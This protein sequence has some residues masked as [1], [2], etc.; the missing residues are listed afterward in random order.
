[1]QRPTGV[2][3]LAVLA[4]IFGALGIFGS[5]AIIGGGALLASAT[6]VSG[7]IVIVLGILTLVTSALALAF[8]IGAWM[9]K[10]WAWTLGVANYIL[11]LVLSVIFIITGV[12]S[13]GG[14]IVSIIIAGA[15]L[16]YLMTPPVKQAFGRA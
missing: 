11:S 14:E 7:G 10:P 9:L 4:I 13:I 2:T 5:F 1:M 15:I 8:G 12:S 3:V 16:Y 6:G